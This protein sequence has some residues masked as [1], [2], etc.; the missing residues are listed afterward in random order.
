MHIVSLDTSFCCVVVRA[1]SDKDREPAF[2]RRVTSYNMMLDFHGITGIIWQLCLDDNRDCGDFRVVS[3]L[4][5][6]LLIA[7]LLARS[8]EVHTLVR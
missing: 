1:P 5:V 6:W 8:G 2:S 7:E 3:D 4:E